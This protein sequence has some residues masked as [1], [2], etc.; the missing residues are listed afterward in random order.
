[1]ISV[2]VTLV[3]RQP[4]AILV[5][6][7]RSKQAGGMALDGVAVLQP[8]RRWPPACGQTLPEDLVGA[9][10]VVPDRDSFDRAQSSGPVDQPPPVWEGDQNIVRELVLLD[11]IDGMYRR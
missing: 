5:G 3:P 6:R 11:H 1:M 9:R 8:A 4:L 10:L 2:V 7:P